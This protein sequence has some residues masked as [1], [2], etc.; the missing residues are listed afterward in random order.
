MYF[1]Y[2]LQFDKINM[3]HIKVNINPEVLQWAREEAGYTVNEIADKLQAIDY[4]TWEKD[5]KNIPLGKLKKAAG[6]YKRQVAVF[7]L[8]YVPKKLE[9]QNDFRNLKPS[10]SNLSKEVLLV[11]RRAARLQHIAR[12]L[13]GE[14][15]WQKKYEWQNEVQQF[16]VSSKPDDAKINRWL[17]KRLD[18]D[19]EDQLQWQNDNEAYRQWRLAVEEKLGILVF[20]F[21]MPMEELQGFCFTESFPYV[22]VT[23]SR[24]SYYGRL[25]TIF[26]ELAHIIRHHSGMCLMDFTNTQ[27]QKQEEFECN[28]FAGKFLVPSSQVEA[29]D[30]L[31]E[32]RRFANKLGVS[33]EVYLR[34][35]K[36]EGL[37]SDVKFF[38]LLDQIKATYK[39]SSDKRFVPVMPEVKSKASRGETFFNMVLDAVNNNQISYTEASDVLDLRVNRL[40]NEL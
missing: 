15:Y 33:R 16:I 37:I 2:W 17:R 5:G 1:Y 7:F 19:L 27:K 36:D 25:F 11:L 26:H 39:K 20:Q 32:I 9:K 29:T 18:I 24:Q 8:P 6:Y 34:R 12:E 3:S 38:T 21:P 28:A 4:K 23:N 14:S 40:V 30:D 22:I 35:M 13:R 31:K 10:E